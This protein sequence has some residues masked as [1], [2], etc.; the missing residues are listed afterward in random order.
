MGL[1]CEGTNGR[2]E[3]QGSMKHDESRDMGRFVPMKKKAY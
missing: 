1:V 2:C 3:L